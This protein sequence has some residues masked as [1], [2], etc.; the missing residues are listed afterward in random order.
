MCKTLA[1][2]NCDQLTI[3]SSSMIVYLFL[4]EIITLLLFS[5]R[6]EIKEKEL[7][8]LLASIQERQEDH[9]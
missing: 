1:G 4:I 3:T 6:K 7:L 2:N 9:I 5:K 8:Y